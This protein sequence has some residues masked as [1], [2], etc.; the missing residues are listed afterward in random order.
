MILVDLSQVM[1]SNLMAHIVHGSSHAA[2]VV[3]ERMIRHMVLNS[4]R[5]YRCKFTEE[6]GELVICCDDRNNWRKQIFPFYKASRKKNRDA[7]PID[8]DNVFTILNKVRDEIKENMPYKVVQVEHA[9][10]DDIIG[11]ICNVFGTYH[12]S[13]DKILILSGDKDFIQLQKFMNVYQYAPVQKKMISSDNPERFLREHIML[14][15]TGD[16]VPNFLSDDDTFMDE[17]KRQKTVSR[18]KLATWVTMDPAVVCD[19]DMK[20]RNYKR[21]EK[22]I[23]LSQ[24]PS[25]IQEQCLAAFN[26]ATPASRSNIFKYFLENRLSNLTESIGDF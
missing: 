1:I 19:T 18:E 4:L 17:A 5:S 8:W 7:S 24:I 23:D 10:A 2:P 20:L 22:M 12:P 6:Y 3:E 21:N 9:E 16:G 13:A 25:E 26:D 14:G 15:D 11:S